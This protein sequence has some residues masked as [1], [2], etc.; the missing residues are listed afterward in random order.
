MFKSRITPS[1]RFAICSFKKFREC[2]AILRRAAI[3]DKKPTRAAKHKLPGRVP[4]L[5]PLSKTTERL[6][7]TRLNSAWKAREARMGSEE[8]V[9]AILT[10]GGENEICLKRKSRG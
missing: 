3:K 6:R 1:I 8:V 5:C 4:S 10:G 7:T 2:A 9:V